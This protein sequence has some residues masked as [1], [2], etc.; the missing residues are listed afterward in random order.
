[1]SVEGI[2]LTYH[3]TTEEE[4]YG[5]TDARAGRQECQLRK[6][7]WHNGIVTEAGRAARHELLLFL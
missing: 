5:I 2:M 4:K 3:K 1:M 6:E 7:F